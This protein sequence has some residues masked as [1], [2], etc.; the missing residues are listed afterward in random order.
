MQSDNWKILADAANQGR[1]VPYFVDSERTLLDRVQTQLDLSD[2]DFWHFLIVL[3][4][5]VPSVAF[6]RNV[7]PELK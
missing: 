2:K 1:G 7:L 4:K 3:G 6:L 5:V